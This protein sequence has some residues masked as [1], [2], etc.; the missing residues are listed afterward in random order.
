MLLWQKRPVASMGNASIPDAMGRRSALVRGVGAL[1]TAVSLGGCTEDVGEDLPANEHWPVDRVVPD[2]PIQQRADVL[3]AGIESM[4][5]RD[6]TN[7]EG[8]EAALGEED[9]AFAAVDVTD[10]R[11]D[12]EYVDTERNRRELLEVI[13]FVTG[14]FAA[15]VDAGIDARSL[16]LTVFSPGR[17]TVGVAEVAAEWA[18]DYNGGE[19]S[20][21]E[22][23]ELA[24][25]TIESR[26]RPPV[27]D[28]APDE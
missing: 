6:I 13:A 22:F 19:L 15:L 20:A 23:G 2:L 18:R 12:V 1:A 5:R 10:L 14:G 21:G 4:A 11:L 27:L 9:I 3:T 7:L 24:V 17:S 28:V 8:F 16:E 25:A 26:R